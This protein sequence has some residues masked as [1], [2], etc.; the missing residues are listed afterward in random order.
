MSD[1]TE[2]VSRSTCFSTTCLRERERE[3]ERE[4]RDQR[5]SKRERERERD[6]EREMRDMTRLHSS[7]APHASLLRVLSY[8]R[9][10]THIAI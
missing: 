1:I 5:E 7:A 9:I 10:Y 6:R 2:F 4:Q 8:E 3:R